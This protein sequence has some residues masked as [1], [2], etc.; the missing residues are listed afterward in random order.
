MNSAHKRRPHVGEDISRPHGV[1]SIWYTVVGLLS[2]GIN[3][4]DWHT[5]YDSRLAPSQWETALL[6]NAVSHWLGANLESALQF[7]PTMDHLACAAP[8]HTRRFN[9]R[10]Y[11]IKHAHGFS[12]FCFVVVILWILWIVNVASYVSMF[13]GIV[14]LVLVQS[15]GLRMRQY[16]H[17]R[18]PYNDIRY[19]NIKALLSE[20]LMKQVVMRY[21]IQLFQVPGSWYIAVGNRHTTFS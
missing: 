5:S 19:Y 14:S 12:V 4:T 16:S 7:I 21:D 20:Y 2:H 8:G 3:P 6:C 9:L 17:L 15:Y 13:F 1:W 11:P 18:P 10:V